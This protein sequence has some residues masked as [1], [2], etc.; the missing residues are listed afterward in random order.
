M[1][2][3]SNT[4]NI[5]DKIYLG[6][7][8]LYYPRFSDK[9]Y[10]R[11]NYLVKK[12]MGEKDLDAL[13]IYSTSPSN[14]AIHYLT[15]Y[16]TRA[17]TYLVYPLEGEPILILNFYNHIPCAF[18]MSIVRDI[19]WHGNDPVNALTKALSE[20]NLVRSRIGVVGYESIPYK[21]IEGLRR[22]LP[23]NI[24]ID[25]SKEYNS[26]RWIRSEE[27]LEWFRISA[28][29]TDRAMET[30]KEAIRPGI[31]EFELNA[32]VYR[33]V[34]REG[35]DIWISYISSTDMDNPDLF[36]PW[37][38]PRNRRIK[39]GDV[40][41]TEIS[42]NYYTY[43]T[44]LHRPFSVGI[45]PSQIYRK[46][47][48]VALETF[49]RVVKVLR[50]GA[51]T[52]D[53]INA[54]SIIEEY[55]FSIYDSLVHGESGKYP[56]IGTMSSPHVKESFIFRE[57]MVLVVQPQPITKDYKAGIQLG[58]TVVVKEGGAEILNKYPFEF[59]TCY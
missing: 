42:A 59:I 49:Y 45:E 32:E 22:S 26:I 6:D 39:K 9:E 38:F 18:S 36:V 16:V 33:S 40:I 47:F 11:R 4:I 12:L 19:R 13:L 35:G 15:N 14:G 52:N 53:V 46:L 31:S 57:N 5:P 25:V 8:I 58:A 43:I 17:P 34:I 27:E 50:P 37:Q 10:E 24:F 2:M 48:E 20:R 55:G 41:I 1:F 56:E 44:Q 23:H 7:A 21:I 3:I 29:L 51:T 28:Q 54:A 30:L